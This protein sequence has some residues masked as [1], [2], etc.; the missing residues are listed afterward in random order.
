MPI[1]PKPTPIKKETIQNYQIF[2]DYI[3]FNSLVFMHKININEINIVYTSLFFIFIFVHLVHVVYH[4]ILHNCFIRYFC[5]WT[6][7]SLCT[8]FI[9]I[10]IPF[11]LLDWLF[12][13]VYQFINN[14]AMLR[15]YWKMNG[16]RVGLN[17][18]KIS[19]WFKGITEFI[20]I[21]IF[22]FEWN[23]SGMWVCEKF[24]I[25]IFI[26]KITNFLYTAQ[27]FLCLFHKTFF[28]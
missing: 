8:T 19:S 12:H 11:N 25:G 22:A 1:S 13:F 26:D 14:P 2:S 15:H 21:E 9:E 4:E 17:L 5:H 3:D 10:L 16:V 23:Y 27:N 7:D 6:I 24:K 28:P 20:S 18:H